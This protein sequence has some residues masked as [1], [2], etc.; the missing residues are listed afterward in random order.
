VVSLNLSE[1]IA[2]ALDEAVKK[3]GLT[4]QELIRQM[5]THCLDDMGIHVERGEEL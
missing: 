1:S 5:L 3:S 4:K 2:H